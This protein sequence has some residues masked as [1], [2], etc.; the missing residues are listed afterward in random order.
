MRVHRRAK[1]TQR[2][3]ESWRSRVLIRKTRERKIDDAYRRGYSQ[4][5]QEDWIGKAGLAAFEA[6]AQSEREE[7]L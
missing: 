5:P 4:Q 1:L 7:P 3:R 2:L 6:L